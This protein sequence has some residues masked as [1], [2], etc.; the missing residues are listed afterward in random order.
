MTQISIINYK[1]NYAYT[2]VN[3][4]IMSLKWGKDHE[5][6]ARKEMKHDG[7]KTVELL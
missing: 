1:R 4:N 2:S 5:D 3:P 6:T 7:F